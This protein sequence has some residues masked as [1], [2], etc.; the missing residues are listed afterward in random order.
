MEREN[1]GELSFSSSPPSTAYDY[2]MEALVRK[3]RYKSVT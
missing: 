1:R 2:H 3:I